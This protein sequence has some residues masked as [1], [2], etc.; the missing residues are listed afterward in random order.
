MACLSLLVKPP[1]F[2]LQT[3]VESGSLSGLEIG[4]KLHGAK[5]E[6]PVQDGGMKRCRPT[7]EKPAFRN[8]SEPVAIVLEAEVLACVQRAQKFFGRHRLSAAL[9]YDLFDGQ[10]SMFKSIKKVYCGSRHDGLGE[11]QRDQGVKDRRRRDVKRERDPFEH[12][13]RNTGQ[14]Q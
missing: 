7:R 12:I 6:L 14:L 8:G 13:L 1:I 4:L 11:E 10:R 9:T 2:R 3:F 5:V